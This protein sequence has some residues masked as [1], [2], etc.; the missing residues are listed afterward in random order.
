MLLSKTVQLFT[1]GSGECTKL[2]DPP[3]TCTASQHLVKL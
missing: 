3:I 2:G 1:L